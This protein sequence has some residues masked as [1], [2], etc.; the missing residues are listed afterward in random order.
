MASIE[1]FFDIGSPYSYLA[2]TQLPALEQ[3]HHAH[4][5]T[6]RPFLLGAVHKATH[7]HSMEHGGQA[8]TRYQLKDLEDWARFYNVPFRM[9][10][11]FP[12]F[13]LTPQRVLTAALTE[14]GEAPMRT[15][16]GALFSAYWVDDRNIT[17]PEVILDLTAGLD[18]DGEALL[19][20]TADPRIKNALR[21]TTDEAVERGAFGAPTFF[22]GETMFFGNDRLPLLEHALSA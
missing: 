7:N 13:T 6:W 21:A 18:L 11:H 15:L 17:Q 2:S 4:T 5:L 19:T 22:I 20:A 14:L 8:R 9:S 16:A 12:L 1:F 10:S 3:R